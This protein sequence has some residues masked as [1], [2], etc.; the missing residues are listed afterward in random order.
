MFGIKCQLLKAVQSFYTK[1]KAC[2]R[3]SSEESEWFEV[4]G[5]LKQGYVMSLWLFNLF[6]DGLI[7][8]VKEKVDDVGLTM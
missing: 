8:K 3:V 4:Y 7:K 6:M 2:V 1:R 5:G